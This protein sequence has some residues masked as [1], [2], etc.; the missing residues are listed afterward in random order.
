MDVLVSTDYGIDLVE[1]V[2]VEA[3]CTLAMEM[4][5]KP[6]NSEVSVTF[7]NNDEMAQLNKQYRGLDGPTDVL[8]FECDNISDE[9]SDV[10]HDTFPYQLGDI[11]IAP[12]VA[13]AQSD[14]FGT[15]VTA[16]IE[17]LLVHGILHLCGWDHQN[18]D[19]AQ[20]MEAREREILSAWRNR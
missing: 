15:S 4:E 16:E 12:D 5:S 18:D 19:D 20:A 13:A 14:D 6:A 7:V 8:S 11:I 17:L 10:S 2:E 3:L 9:M 1:E